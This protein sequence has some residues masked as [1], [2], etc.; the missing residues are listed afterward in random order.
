M[1]VNQ[2]YNTLAGSPCIDDDWC[3]QGLVCA[4]IGELRCVEYLEP[5]ADCSDLSDYV[6]CP[7]EEACDE[8]L[9][10]CLPI[11]DEEGE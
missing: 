10:L 7:P 5:G 2:C 3:Q 4:D 11:S 1:P 9:L 8:E 6:F